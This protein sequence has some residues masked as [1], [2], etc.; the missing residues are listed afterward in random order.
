MAAPGQ[1]VSA[2]ARHRGQGGGD[3][4]VAFNAHDYAI[5]VPLPPQPEAGAAWARIVDTNLPPPADFD[6]AG[7][8]GIK[9]TYTLAPHS[10]IMLSAKA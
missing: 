7:V 1:T 3:L 8:P 4:Y 6:P 2:V 5:T 10:S 9:S